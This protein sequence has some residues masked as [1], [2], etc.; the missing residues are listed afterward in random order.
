MADPMRHNQDV[1]KATFTKMCGHRARSTVLR[2]AQRG[3]VR[4]TADGRVDLGDPVN[5]AYYHEAL[6]SAAI[7]A[8]PAIEEIREK[9][10]SIG[11]SD[12]GK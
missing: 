6:A 8:A 7:C 4:L 12:N 2:A 1:K 5:A 9:L 3:R 11:G 10:N